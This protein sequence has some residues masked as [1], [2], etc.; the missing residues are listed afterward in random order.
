[1]KENFEPSY[2]PTINDLVESALRTC[3]CYNRSIENMKNTCIILKLSQPS[4]VNIQDKEKF[5]KGQIFYRSHLEEKRGIIPRAYFRWNN[6]M[7]TQDVD[8]FIYKTM[9]GVYENVS[10]TG[11]NGL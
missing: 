10:V 11:R 5:Q 4:K 8:S 6:Q 7:H 2:I 3:Q 9:F 1:M